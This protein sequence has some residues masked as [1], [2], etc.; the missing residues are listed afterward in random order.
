MISNYNQESL[1]DVIKKYRQLS[2][3]N[4]N[5]FI[6][7]VIQDIKKEFNTNDIRVKIHAIQKLFFLY[8]NFR[9]IKWA[10]FNSLDIMS[11][12]GMKGKL[13]GYLLSSLQFKTQEDFI[14]LVSN[15]IRSDLHKTNLNSNGLLYLLIKNN[16]LF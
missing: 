8:L 13:F 9:D 5:S 12:C 4:S 6:N 7:K 2:L 15:Q 1:R 11:T 16:F 14:L 10:S 3:G